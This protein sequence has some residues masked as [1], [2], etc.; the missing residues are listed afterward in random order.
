MLLNAKRFRVP[1]PSCKR[2]RL[3]PTQARVTKRGRMNA[4]WLSPHI[5]PLQ[6]LQY[7]PLIYERLASMLKRVGDRHQ[8]RPTRPNDLD[9]P[10]T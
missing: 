8:Q 10:P 7:S 1:M 6:A 9:R 3:H 5:Y 4:M 2:Q